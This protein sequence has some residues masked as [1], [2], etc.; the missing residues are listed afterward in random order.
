MVY[1]SGGSITTS[2]YEIRDLKVVGS[3]RDVRILD[4]SLVSGRT[5]VR[6]SSGEITQDLPGGRESYQVNVVIRDQGWRV[7]RV[8]RVVS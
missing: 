4:Y 8:S 7:T 1:E 3:E 2:D 5:V 6:N